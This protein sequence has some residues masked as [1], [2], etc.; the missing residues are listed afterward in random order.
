MPIYYQWL[1]AKLKAQTEMEQGVSQ[2]R[3]CDHPVTEDTLSLLEGSTVRPF[4]TQVQI[5]TPLRSVSEELWANTLTL[6]DICTNTYKATSQT[7]SLQV[8]IKDQDE[9]SKVCEC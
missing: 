3:S 5:K 1:R 4:V 9:H 8:S 6:Q 2:G 7:V